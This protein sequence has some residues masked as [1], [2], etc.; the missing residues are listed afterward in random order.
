[1]TIT[2]VP[3]RHGPE[4]CEPLLGDV[5]GFLLTADDLP[6]VYVS[7]DNAAVELVAEIVDRAGPVDVAVLFAGAARAPQL[8]DGPLTLS[9]TAAV[10]A[11]RILGD[12][13]IVPVHA[14]GWAHFTEGPDDLRA[15]FAAAGLSNRLL[16]PIAGYETTVTRVA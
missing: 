10:E 15:G 12:A 3:A 4:G 14:E 13:V 11:A 16:I 1:M 6:T 9:A 2:G 8:V 7:G 5:T